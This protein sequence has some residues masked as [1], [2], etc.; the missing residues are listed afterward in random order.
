[1]IIIVL[2]FVESEANVAKRVFS[3][4]LI[5]LITT[6]CVQ[7]SPSTRSPIVP[8]IFIIYGRERVTMFQL[9]ATSFPRPDPS[10]AYPPLSLHTGLSFRSVLFSSYGSTRLTDVVF[11]RRLPSYAI[12][13]N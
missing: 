1:M 4:S 2:S 13:K 3:F 7:Q 10:L 8:S 5:A 9:T 11:L 12:H 6:L